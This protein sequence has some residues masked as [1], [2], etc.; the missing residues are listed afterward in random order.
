MRKMAL[1]NLQCVSIA[2]IV[3]CPQFIFCFGGETYV[4]LHLKQGSQS[5]L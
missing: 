3:L 4:K 1:I 5:K 2:M